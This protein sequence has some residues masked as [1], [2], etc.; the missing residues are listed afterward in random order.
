[1]FLA[2]NNNGIG[3]SE[4]YNH[5][6]QIPS[7][8]HETINITEINE[9]NRQLILLNQNKHKTNKSLI[10]LAKLIIDEMEAANYKLSKVDSDNT[11]ESIRLLLLEVRN[12][13]KESLTTDDLQKL[14]HAT[15]AVNLLRAEH[16][17]EKRRMAFASINDELDNLKSV[18]DEKLKWLSQYVVSSMGEAKVSAIETL[19][20][21]VDATKNTE[22]LP[23]EAKKHAKEI[24]SIWLPTLLYVISLIEL[25]CYV[26]F[27]CIK[28][29]KTHGF[30]KID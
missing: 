7:P 11:T 19:N 15:I 30:K 21:F 16:K 17:M 9:I 10:P 6:L 20:G 8:Y 25:V 22:N 28:R 4:I 2:Q 24:K 27:F 1:M 3:S 13:L 26:A 12:R 29:K 14:V 18:V 23:K 5:L